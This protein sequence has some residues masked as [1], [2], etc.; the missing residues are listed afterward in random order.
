MTS[1]KDALNHLH[2]P[3]ITFITSLIS[4]YVGCLVLRCCF[5]LDYCLPYL[6]KNIIQRK[7]ASE[8]TPLG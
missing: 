7:I 8:K 2:L 5:I 1:E 4:Y 3:N 6:Q